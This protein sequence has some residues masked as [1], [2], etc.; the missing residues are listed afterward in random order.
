ME[1]AKAKYPAKTVSQGV[2]GKDFLCYINYGEGATEANPVWNLLGGTDSDDLGISAEVNTKQTK[3]SGYWQEGVITG[4]SGEYS[5]E[6]TVLRDNTAQQVIEE[7]MYDDEITGEKNAL[8]MALV[9][10]VTK[11]YKEFWCAPTSWELS[12]ASDDTATYSFS[13][14]IIGKPLKKTGFTLTGE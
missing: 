8:H 13:G 4:K 14:T 10:K 11:E 12:A 9:D 7:F 3:N 6:M 1:I 2:P 5:S